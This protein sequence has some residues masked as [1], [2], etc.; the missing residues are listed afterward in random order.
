MLDILRECASATQAGAL[1]PLDA[2]CVRSLLYTLSSTMSPIDAD[3]QTL[4]V[5]AG[6]MRAY[7]TDVEIQSSAGAV[8]SRLISMWSWDPAIKRQ[9]INEGMLDFVLDRIRTGDDS[10]ILESHVGILA[11][12]AR[13]EVC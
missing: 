4:A 1:P 11:D 12:L 13:G 6:V 7:S 2:G 10:N 3:L 5:C 8:V 9:V